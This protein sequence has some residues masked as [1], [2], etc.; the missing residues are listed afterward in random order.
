MAL[1]GPVTSLGPNF[2]GPCC[3]VAGSTTTGG[4][5]STFGIGA[6]GDL[7]GVGGAGGLATKVGFS[8][9]PLEK[10]IPFPLGRLGLDVRTDGAGDFGFSGS[11]AAMD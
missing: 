9:A 2:A 4:A 1:F 7:T 8:G 6:Q 11:F 10:T 5:L 3:N